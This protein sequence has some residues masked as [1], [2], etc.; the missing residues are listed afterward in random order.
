[1][2]SATKRLRGNDR[3]AFLSKILFPPPG[4]AAEAEEGRALAPKF[5]VDGLVT[6]VAT[7]AASGDVLMVAH[8]N[9]E[10]T[11]SKFHVRLSAA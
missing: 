1:L 7:D 6:C 8:M 3:E 10:A 11:G 9:A 2:E 4:S 5:D